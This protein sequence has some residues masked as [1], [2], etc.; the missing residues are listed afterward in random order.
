MLHEVLGGA[1]AKILMIFFCKVDMF[2]LLEELPQQIIPYYIT[3]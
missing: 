1:R 2:A 3:E